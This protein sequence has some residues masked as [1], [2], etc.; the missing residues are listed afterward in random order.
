MIHGVNNVTSLTWL[1]HQQNSVNS[2]GYSI[3]PVHS[4][5]VLSCPRAPP[6]IS[7][8]CLLTLHWYSLLQS[9]SMSPPLSPLTAPRLPTAA[10]SMPPSLQC[11]HLVTPIKFKIK[12]RNQ[13]LINVHACK[14]EAAGLS[15]CGWHCVRQSDLSIRRFTHPASLRITPP[16]TPPATPILRG[17]G[18]CSASQWWGQRPTGTHRPFSLR[19]L[20]HN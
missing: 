4:S 19:P 7:H 15:G 5:H 12:I 8:D 20:Y 1:P 18:T 13:A 3:Q 14:P 16:S 6:L 10:P 9:P 11:P 2:N 17:R